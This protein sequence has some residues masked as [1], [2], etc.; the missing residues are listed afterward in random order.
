[1]LERLRR[2]HFWWYQGPMIVWA[3]ALFAQSSIPGGNFP[4]FGIFKYD[5]VFHAVFY[6][7]LAW[8]THRAL[9][10]QTRFPFFARHHYLFTFIVVAIYGATDEVHQ[11]FVPQR[12]ASLFDWFADCLGAIVYLSYDRLRM[13]MRP[14]TVSRKQ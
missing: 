11:Y 4:G 9:V 7:V 8:A 3:V 5:K 2:N 6:I 12:S 14:A 10:W 13:W 1:M